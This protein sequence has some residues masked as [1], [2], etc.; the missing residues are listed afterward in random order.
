[1]LILMIL[2]N[3]QNIFLIFRDLNFILKKVMLTQN[4]LYSAGILLIFECRIFRSLLPARGF[5]ND[6]NL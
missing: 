3:I 1:M 2:K 6:Q 5:L 4:I